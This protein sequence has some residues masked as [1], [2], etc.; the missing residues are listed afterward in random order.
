MRFSGLDTTDF[1][2]LIEGKDIREIEIDIRRFIV[3][4][5]ALH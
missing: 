2:S 5:K 3:S 4:L 1:S